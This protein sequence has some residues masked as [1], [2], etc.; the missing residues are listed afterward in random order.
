VRQI[1][2]E[3]R[4]GARARQ[5]YMTVTRGRDLVL[6]LLVLSLSSGIA[7][8]IGIQAPSRPL[9]PTSTSTNLKCWDW[10]RDVRCGEGNLRELKV[11]LGRAGWFE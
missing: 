8:S 6:E 11:A 4:G 3:A 9:S 5:S 10:R 2:E 7:S 1:R